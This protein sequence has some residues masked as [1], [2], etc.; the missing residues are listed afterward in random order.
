MTLNSKQRT[1]V[2]ATAIAMAGLAS[3]VV[4]ETSNG[5]SAT[6]ANLVRDPAFL[7]G[8]TNWSTTA[9]GSLSMADGH[10]GHRAIRL[11]NSS[12]G[13]MTLALNDRINTVPTTTA[14]ATYQAGAW[15]STDAPGLTAGV[16]MMEYEG[17][18]MHGSKQGS[19]W[20]RTNDWYYVTTSYKAVT[21]VSSIDFNVL[22]WSIPKGKSL[23][24]S[25]PSLVQTS[26]TP[27]SSATS[28]AAPASS[29]VQTTTAVPSSIAPTTPDYTPSAPVTSANQP[30]PLSSSSASSPTASGS[31]SPSPAPS[32]YQLVWS[33]D[34]NSLNTGKWNVRNNTWSSN[35]ES[36][37]TSRP[38]NVFISDGTLT[39]RAIKQT[40][41]AYGTTRQYTSGY[42]D[43]IGKES[44]Q[45]GRIEMRA[46]LP[47]A[48][49]M[50]PAFWLRN[51]VGLGELDIMEAVGGMNDSSVQTV[52]QSTNGD[53]ARK[54]HQ[55]TLPSGTNADWHVY[56][57]DR[58]PGYMNW[59][60]DNRL[61]FTVTQSELSWL[62]PTFNSPMNIRLNL[63]V[64]GSMPAYYQLPVGA[65]PTGQSD[66]VVDYV[67]VYQK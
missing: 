23:Y 46:K 45:Y 40:Y 30:P 19:A 50:W 53:L 47:I 29:T 64:G 52:H 31:S 26:P 51:D 28:S 66:Y 44:W 43:T 16:R 61:V 34:F 59:Y 24:I 63:Q 36:I 13:T 17:S 42:L 54:G 39:L 10:D 1:I 67:R 60:V 7:T 55:D 9:G 65:T 32:G 48:Q 25:E 62:D 8:V 41:T 37:D 12:A 15:V 4:I 56:A 49:G 5:V 35:E 18:I 14:G 38:A 33:D 2:G 58:E 20:L 22:G 57:V 21:S 11:L 27:S 6:S 3:I